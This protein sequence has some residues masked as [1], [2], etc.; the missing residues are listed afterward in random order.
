[1]RVA[2]PLSNWSPI[3]GLILSGVGPL[4]SHL[5]ANGMVLEASYMMHFCILCRSRF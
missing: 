4:V 3:R 1:M 2:H 5:L